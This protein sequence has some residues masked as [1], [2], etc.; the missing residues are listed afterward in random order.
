MKGYTNPQL[1]VTPEELSGLIGQ[2]ATARPLVLDLRPPEQYTE[3]HIPGAIHLEFRVVWQE[4]PKR[5]HGSG[6]VLSKDWMP[7]DVRVFANQ[8]APR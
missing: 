2:A 6:A 7:V 8:I 5:L 1:L 3:G 4:T